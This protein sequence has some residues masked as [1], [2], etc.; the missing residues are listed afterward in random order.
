MRRAVPCDAC[1]AR[2]ES[3][4]SPHTCLAKPG[5]RVG[6]R[7]REHVSFEA[8]RRY[9]DDPY[10][11][12]VVEAMANQLASGR[13]TQVQLAEAAVLACSLYVERKLRREGD[14]G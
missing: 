1:G 2:R 11:H 7:S 10:Y 8:Q 14:R 9:Q 12:Q 4:S 3:A 13:L 5:N 6:Q